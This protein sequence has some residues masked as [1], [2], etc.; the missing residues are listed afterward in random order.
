MALFSF[1][2]SVSHFQRESGC[3]GIRDVGRHGDDDRVVAARHQRHHASAC[4]LA[5]D[6]SCVRRQGVAN[7]IGRRGI[8]RHPIRAARQVAHVHQSSS[9][10][11]IVVIGSR[12][13]EGG[14]VAGQWLRGC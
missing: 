6:A 10:A 2:E 12:D 5:V 13:V 3:I 4:E 1:G 9:P 14:A 8:E 11:R 7:E